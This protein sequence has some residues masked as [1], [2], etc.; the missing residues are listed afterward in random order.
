MKRLG[1]LL[2]TVALI[3]SIVGCPADSG[4]E[5][6]PPDEYTL[7]ISSTEGGS[8][9]VPGEGTFTYDEGEVVELMA[10][11]DEGYRFVNWIGEV[12]TIADVNDA[13]TTITVND[14]YSITASFGASV[15]TAGGSGKYATIQEAINAARSGDTIQVAQGTYMENVTVET[16]KSFTL[17]GGWDSGFTSRS[18][19]CRL[20]VIDGKGS[21]SAVQ[22]YAGPS[23][24]IEL[25]ID[26]F[27]IRNGVAELGAGIRVVSDR[28]SSVALLLNNNLIAGNTATN[29]GGG[30]SMES[31]GG[32]IDARVTNSI[33]AENAADAEGGGIR[34]NSSN[35]GVAAL[36]LTRNVIANNTVS[37]LLESEGG[38]DGGGIAVYASGSGSTTVQAMNNVFAANEA[39]YGGGLF[40]YA[41]GPEAAVTMI[42]TNN[43]ITG[44]RAQYGAGI[45]SCSGKT[46]PVGQPGGLIKWVLTNNTVTSNTASQ[47]VG[48]IHMHS[49]STF[50]DGGNMSL[51]MQNDIVHGNSDEQVTF[52]VESGKSGAVTANMSYCN[53]GAIGCD[54]GSTYTTD[55]VINKD[56]L[57]VDPV[58][59]VFLLQEGSPCVDSGDPD[60][61]FNDGRRPPGKGT[62]RN[63]MGA[64]GGP[65]NYGWPESGWDTAGD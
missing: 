56:S 62:E 16:S 32:T 28:G 46:C 25:A 22:V 65:N 60:T 61:A 30:I 26:G 14:G 3:P 37:Y 6:T 58:N 45:F 27:T 2:I 59:G 12:G 55:H 52:R 11:A 64:Y 13:K 15:L 8:V 48:G 50:G 36:T 53:V 47:G 42:L 24:A 51:S 10:D 39:A 20:T 43:I 18:N 23:V 38:W 29:R 17:Q 7:T 1:V 9:T 54:G 21:G 19:D 49:G 57:F 31:A 5:P 33:I 41:W 44:N 35:G 63:D 40:G 34:V 4:P